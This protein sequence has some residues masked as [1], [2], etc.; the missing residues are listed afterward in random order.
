MV[1]KRDRTNQWFF[2]NCKQVCENEACT[3][4]TEERRSLTGKTERK[5]LVLENRGRSK[6]YTCI[7]VMYR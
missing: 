4:K 2:A 1:Q 5:R 6:T 7:F 3:E